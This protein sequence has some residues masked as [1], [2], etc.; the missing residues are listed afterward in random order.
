MATL[1][2]K[3]NFSNPE[4]LAL[5]KTFIWCSMREGKRQKSP[6]DEFSSDWGFCEIETGHA[7][8]IT[9]PKE[10]AKILLKLAQV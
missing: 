8:M 6:R 2:Q 7:A 1:E 9:A 3:V 10:L 5:P 4:A